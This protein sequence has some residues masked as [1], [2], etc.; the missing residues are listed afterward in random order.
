MGANAQTSVPLFVANTVLTAAQQNISA[1]TGVPVFATTA[2]RD[3]AFGGSNKALAAGQLCFLESTAVVQYY[4]GSA[5]ATVGPS[6]TA[7][8]VCVK[9]QTTFTAASTITAD[10]I[11]TSTYKNYLLQI[12]YTAG[13]DLTLQLRA[14]GVTATASEYNEQAL[15]VNS[16]TLTGARTG[17]V[18]SFDLST[19]SSGSLF[20]FAQMTFYQP[21]IAAAT[22]FQNF[23]HYNNS[24]T[25]AQ[26]LRRDWFGTHDLSTAYDG[27]IITV[28]GASTA[29][30]T[31]AVYGYGLTV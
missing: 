5:W 2:T 11:F 29:T 17:P 8:L 26:P 28:G 23:S 27:F 15:T 1:A 19:S 21:Q 12:N 7:S 16:T 20:N 18:A 14:G 4:T 9:A 25:Y 13:G 22:G 30:G 31:Y 6:A 10:S 3:A 24:S